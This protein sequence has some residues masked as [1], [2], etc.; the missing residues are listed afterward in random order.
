MAE[1]QLE[2]ERLVL[3]KWRECDLAP[4][5]SICG[6]PRVMEFVGPPWSEAEASQFIASQRKSQ[7]EHGYCNWAIERKADKALIGFC[8][9][10]P[11]SAGTPVA[12]KPDLGWR[13]AHSA[14]GQGFA[15]EAAAA[16]IAWGF[17]NFPDDA[18]WAK[19]VPANTRSLGLMLRLGMSKVE[20]GDFDHPA[21]L[22]GDPLRRHVLYRI[23]RPR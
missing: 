20:G 7:A 1:L 10:K 6:D 16:C 2:T 17:A 4:F 5:H 23:S 21:L 22:Q 11:G 18:I 9:L 14:W 13:L 12:G 15:R 3:R 8:G 19:T